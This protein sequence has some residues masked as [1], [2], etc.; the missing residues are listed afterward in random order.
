MIWGG[1]RALQRGALSW[2][3]GEQGPWP[4]RPCPACLAELWPSDQGTSPRP[5]FS[6]RTGRAPGPAGSQEGPSGSRSSSLGVCEPLDL[7][8][9]EGQMKQ[10]RK[11]TQGDPVPLVALGLFTSRPAHPCLLV[12]LCKW[13]LIAFF[14]SVPQRMASVARKE[15]SFRWRP[16]FT[17]VET[18]LLIT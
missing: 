12:A 1:L 14:S 17:V 9:A 4:A 3:R 18:K 11:S 13:I 15:I 8:E 2:G 5:G 16:I 6:P 10:G 7:A